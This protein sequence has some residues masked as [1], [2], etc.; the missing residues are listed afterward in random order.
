MNKALLKSYVTGLYAKYVGDLKL[1][2]HFVSD[3]R[4]QEFV[5]DLD[6]SGMLLDE[7]NWSEWY[8]NSYM[9]D[10]PEYI[11]DAS[12]YECRLLLTAMARI[13]KFS[14]G[15]LSNMRRQGVL[16]AIIERFQTLKCQEAV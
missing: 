3:K 10:R 4:L 8:D 13:D 14:P 7:F 6:Q 5:A 15:V 2:N 16:F 12:L 9:V 11:G 1:S